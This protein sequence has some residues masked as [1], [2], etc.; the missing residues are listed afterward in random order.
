MSSRF[1]TLS[2]VRPRRGLI[3]PCKRESFIST[4]TTHS[5]TA[6]NAKPV[7]IAS[8]TT[9]SVS[10]LLLPNM[11]WPLQTTSPGRRPVTTRIWIQRKWY[12]RSSTAWAERQLI[13]LMLA[14]R[15]KKR[16]KNKH[17]TYRTQTGSVLFD[18][19]GHLL[20]RAPSN[21]TKTALMQTAINQL[22]L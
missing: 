10:T 8:H 20:S 12:S 11:P 14:L 21:I 7:L 16:W 13:T 15:L 22:Q 2:R 18:M 3:A 19:I 4:T 5:Y 9:C 17:P 1:S 6:R